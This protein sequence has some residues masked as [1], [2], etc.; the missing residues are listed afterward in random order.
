MALWTLKGIMTGIVSGRYPDEPEAM[1][2]GYRGRP[3]LHQ[4]RCAGDTCRR[5]VEVCLPKALTW[6]TGS[7]ATELRLDYSRCVF[8]GLCEEACP[9]QAVT[10]TR[11]VELAARRKADLT[12]GLRILGNGHASSDASA[13]DLEAEIE[14]TLRDEI[15]RVFGRSLHIR[16]VDAGSC[17]GCESEL[18]ALNNPYYNLHRL[19]I[20]F[21]PSPRFADLLLVTGPVTRPMEEPLRNAYEAMAEPKLVVAVGACACSGGIFPPT[22]FTLG[23]VDRIVPVD[24]YI[25][26]CPPPPVALM[27]GLLVA[28]GRLE[29]KIRAGAV[30][31]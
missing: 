9:E 23:G 6:T 15:T 21:T 2:D 3:T 31:T 19:G 13:A 20:F 30:N 1:P 27:H 4:E 18:Q 5:C 14:S 10:L 25:P 22:A 24:V 16:H 11:N 28:V 8:C 12:V 7:E 26:G 29:P 17:N